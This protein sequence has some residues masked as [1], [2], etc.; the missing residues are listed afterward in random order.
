MSR[1]PVRGLFITGTDTEIGK[2]YAAALIARSLAAAGHRVGVYKPAA[3][4]CTRP[5]DSLVSD[6]AL[7]LWQAAGSPA[8]WPRPVRRCRRT[9]APG[10]AAEGKNSTRAVQRL[11]VGSAATSCWSRA[12]GDVALG[13][14]ELSPTWPTIWASPWSSARRTVR[15]TV[16]QTLIAAATFRGER[17]RH[18]AQ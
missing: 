10:G 7:A 15:S 16:L 4:G 11:D 17:G 9:L 13:E 5:G 12:G 18:R 6:D 3:S 2:T 1:K 8:R 14:D